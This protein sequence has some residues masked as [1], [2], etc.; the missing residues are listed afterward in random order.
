MIYY[1]TTRMILCQLL[2]IQNEF[3]GTECVLRDTLVRTYHKLLDTLKHDFSAEIS[4]TLF[5]AA[6][7]HTDANTGI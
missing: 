3:K 4:S 6:N 1:A 7:V 2:R 5:Y